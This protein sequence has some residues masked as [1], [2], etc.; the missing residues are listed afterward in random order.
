MALIGEILQTLQYFDIF[1]HPLK[2]EEIYNF[3]G[4]KSSVSAINNELGKMV[5]SGQI[6][7]EDGYFH[8]GN[9]RAYI[10]KRKKLNLAA[11]KVLPKAIENGRLIS[12]FPFISSVFISGS[13]SKGVFDEEGDGDFDY[14]IISKSGRLW[15]SKFCLKAYKFL[16][17]G[18]SKKYFCFNY[19]ISEESLEIKEKNIFTATELFTLIP[20]GGNGYY[21]RLISQNLWVQE[22]LP[23][24]KKKFEKFENEIP[25]PFFW[26]KVIQTICYGPIGNLID[27]L[28]MYVNRLRNYLKYYSKYKNDRYDERFRSTRFQA[29]IH[30]SNNEVN[31]V[32]KYVE[33]IEN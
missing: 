15:I 31:Q 23:N 30:P 20:I 18:N 19:F 6:Q 7:K 26:S 13:L 4:T 16:F 12:K 2:A 5:V 27:I 21:N 24:Y 10:E 14:F 1:L 25:A 32:K 17:L 11:S 9:S 33:E 29:K 3:L 8:L 22:F 28:L